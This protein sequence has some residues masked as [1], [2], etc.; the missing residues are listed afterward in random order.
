[1]TH[2]RCGIFGLILCRVIVFLEKLLLGHLAVAKSVYQFPIFLTLYVTKVPL[3]LSAL[4]GIPKQLLLSVGVIHFSV[5]L[6][7]FF[8]DR[9]RQVW[10]M[11]GPAAHKLFADSRP[12]YY[13]AVSRPRVK[14]LSA[15]RVCN[16]AAGTLR[17]DLNYH[18]VTVDLNHSRSRFALD[19][20]SQQ[21]SL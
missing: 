11:P 9:F 19:R 5:R 20:N 10:D 21:F 17:L 15:Q 14:E 7:C 8:P 16:V 2:I 4:I 1:M 12:S 3:V 13:F 6:L 18:Y